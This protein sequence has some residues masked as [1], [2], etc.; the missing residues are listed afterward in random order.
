MR[1]ILPEFAYKLDKNSKL[2]HEF[3]SLSA[4]QDVQI[5]KN[6]DMDF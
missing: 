1:E 2:I 5:S 6:E 3:V 4:L